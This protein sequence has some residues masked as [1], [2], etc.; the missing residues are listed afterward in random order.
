[1][2]ALSQ[3]VAEINITYKGT[4]RVKPA[5]RTSLDAYRELVHWFPEDI[6]GLQELF[7]VAYLNRSNKII[8]VYQVSRGGI[9]GTVADPRLIL[10][11]ALKVAA[12]GM[13]LAHN[14]PSGC[15]RPSRPDEDLTRKIKQGALL[16]DIQVLDHIILAPDGEFFSFADDGIL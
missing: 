9:T 15:L 4:D 7:V 6:I 14:H 16:L 1:M 5:V 12:T 13:I 2:K 11:T 10:A 3:N 8:G